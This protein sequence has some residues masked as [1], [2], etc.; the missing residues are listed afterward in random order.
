MENITFIL[1]VSQSVHGNKINVFEAPGRNTSCAAK[2]MAPK[3]S[4]SLLPAAG[5]IAKN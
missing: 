4:E 5:K 1:E 3:I 2:L